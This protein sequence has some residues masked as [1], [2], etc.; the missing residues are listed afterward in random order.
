M[1]IPGEMLLTA[2]ANRFLILAVRHYIAVLTA[3]LEHCGKDETA[4]LANDIGYYQAVLSSMVEV[5]RI[6]EQSGLP[7]VC[8][9]EACPHPSYC[10]ANFKECPA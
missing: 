8:K 10:A 7:F 1:S 2:K 6:A 3:A 9:C 4:S 5:A